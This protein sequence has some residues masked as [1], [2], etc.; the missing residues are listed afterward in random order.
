MSEHEESV[1]GGREMAR[2]MKVRGYPPRIDATMEQIADVMLTTAPPSA[3]VTQ[4]YRCAEC[5]RIVAWPEV[6]FADHLCEDCHDR[7][8]AS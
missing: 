6:L 5:E 4:D 1:F 8:A 3:T 7:P 2:T